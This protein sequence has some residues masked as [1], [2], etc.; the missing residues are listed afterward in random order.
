MKIEIRNIE[1]SEIETAIEIFSEGFIEEPL[2]II[3]FPELEQ[4][5]RLTRLVY[6]LI[7]F[8]IVPE[9][10]MKLIGAFADQVLA[11]VLDYTPPNTNAV[12]T[13]SLGN[14]VEDMR[15]KANDES[16]NLISEYAMKCGSV[17]PEESHFYL[18]DIAVLKSF[19]G[20]G[21][22]RKLFQHVEDECVRHPAAKCTALDA[23]NPK[24]LLLYESWGYKVFKEIK[25]YDLICYKMKK[26]ISGT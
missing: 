4:R 23:T 1:K 2:H 24:N 26:N 6:E 19:R 12:W 13:K 16:I 15:K 9:M 21:I 11:G 18:N 25:F 8:H 10:N 3:A 14:A 5:K 7:V 17:K 22:G 20:N